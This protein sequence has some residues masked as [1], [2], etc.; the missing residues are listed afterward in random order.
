M[1]EAVGTHASGAGGKGLKIAFV[2][3]LGSYG[4]AS[5]V[6]LANGHFGWW[7]EERVQRQLHEQAL[8]RLGSGPAVDPSCVTQAV[9]L[10]T[11]FGTISRVSFIKDLD[12]PLPAIVAQQRIA[13]VNRGRAEAVSERW[14]LLALSERDVPPPCLA[15]GQKEEIDKAIRRCG[16]VNRRFS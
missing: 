7:G 10:Q 12:R 13:C 4:V 6:G 15:I 9:R 5:L 16:F 14:I 3:L 2:A 11:S 1:S 8:A